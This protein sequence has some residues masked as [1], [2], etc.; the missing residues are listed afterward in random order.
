MKNEYDIASIERI[1][2][3]FLQKKMTLSVAESV[4]SGHLQAACSLAPDASGFFQGGIT[5]YNSAQKTRHLQV[6]P[7]SALEHNGVAQIISRQMALQSN[8]FFLSEYA[9]GITGY[10]AP[11]PEKGIHQLFAYLAIA[12][13]NTIV[14][15]EK[16][17]IGSG[18]DN[19]PAATDSHA[20]QI[21]YTNQALRHL[22]SV[23]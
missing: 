11:V 19:D 20:I 12:R 5:V 22:A 23:I 21:Y 3:I 10:A 9:I 13:N 18:T 15:E 1:R 8:A 14:L 6:E 2:T 4:T 16:I 17:E 7:I